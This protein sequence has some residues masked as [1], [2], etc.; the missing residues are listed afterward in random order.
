MKQFPGGGTRFRIRG[1]F[2]ELP[3][4]LQLSFVCVHFVFSTYA[5]LIQVKLIEAQTSMRFAFA[6]RTANSTKQ[7]EDRWSQLMKQMQLN[8]AKLN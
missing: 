7:S 6:R 4:I 1:A 3:G 5:K 8:E 2:L